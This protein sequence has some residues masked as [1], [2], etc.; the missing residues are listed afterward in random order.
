[1]SVHKDTLQGLNEALEYAKGN[2]ELKKTEAEISDE[3]IRF[4][5]IFNKLS[6]AN[7]L[8]VINYANALL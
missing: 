1:M 2:L 5:S 6:E 4:Y 3:E 8:K 7:K